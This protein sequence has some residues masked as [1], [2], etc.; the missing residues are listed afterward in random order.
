MISQLAN[1]LCY[2][3]AATE[4]ADESGTQIITFALQEAIYAR[5]QPVSARELIRSGVCMQGDVVYKFYVDTDTTI[6]IKDRIQYS[7]IDYE[8]IELIDDP[9]VYK[10][11]LGRKVI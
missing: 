2:I 5:V 9:N 11:V 4:T 10:C 3:Y 1:E 7:S 6:D 8:V